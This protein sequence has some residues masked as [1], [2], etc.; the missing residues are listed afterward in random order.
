[1]QN[2]FVNTICEIRQR[3]ML[4]S[5]VKE[6]PSRM[7]TPAAERKRRVKQACHV[8]NPDKDVPVSALESRADLRD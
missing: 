2:D 3:H 1:M 4:S 6:H 5:R 8:Q 7:P